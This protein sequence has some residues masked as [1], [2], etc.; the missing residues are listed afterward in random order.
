[1][2]KLQKIRLLLNSFTLL[3]FTLCNE[4]VNVPAG[5]SYPLPV[6]K[7]NDAIELSN[8]HTNF[9]AMQFIEICR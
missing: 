3:L 5:M 7:N 9:Q 8:Y 2:S 4:L 6:G 1:M